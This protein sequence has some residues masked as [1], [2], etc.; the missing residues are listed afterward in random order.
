MKDRPWIFVPSISMRFKGSF[1]EIYEMSN[2]PDMIYYQTLPKIYQLP[3]VVQEALRQIV[4]YFH[5][6]G[7]GI[8]LP[9]YMRFNFP[10][11]IKSH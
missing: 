9:S 4:H 7:K 3:L 2:N 1:I 5:Y 6:N 11:T 8:N 10:T